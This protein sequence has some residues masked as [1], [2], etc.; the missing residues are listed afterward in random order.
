LVLSPRPKEGK[1][2]TCVGAHL[3]PVFFKALVLSY[4]NAS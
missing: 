3:T 1:E 2:P 4:S